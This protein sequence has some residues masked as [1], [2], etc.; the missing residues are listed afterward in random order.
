MLCPSSIRH[1]EHN[2]LQARRLSRR[3]VN[4]R[5]TRR[6]RD[7]SQ[8]DDQVTDLPIEDIGC[9]ETEDTPC[10]VLVAVD[11]TEAGEVGSRLKRGKTV[12]VA[13]DQGVVVVDDRRRDNISTLVGI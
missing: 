8:V 6:G 11:D 10:L 13:D 1:L 2:V 3:P 5:S 9:P 7:S 12:G 4:A